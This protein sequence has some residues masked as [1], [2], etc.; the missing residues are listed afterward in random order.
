[1]IRLPHTLLAAA[2][3]A[4]LRRYQAEIDAVGDYPGRVQA[5]KDRFKVRNV[6]TN[7]TFA[8]VREALSRMCSGARR[9][10]YC[11]DSVADEVEHIRPKDLYPEAVFVW[12]NYLYACGPCNGGKLN[13]FQVL[14]AANGRLQDLTRGRGDPVVPPPANAR[15]VFIDPRQEDG[16]DFIRLDL[17]GGTL[18]FV[19]VARP[20]RKTPSAPRRRSRS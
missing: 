19:P 10:M 2:A 13:R 14:L 11:E 6:P 12:E 7:R 4:T 9:C 5:G 1:M 15:P 8:A 3:V 20:G 18:R 17:K 16:L